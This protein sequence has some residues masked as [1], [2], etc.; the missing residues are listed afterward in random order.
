MQRNAMRDRPLRKAAVPD[1][2][3]RA[4]SGLQTEI[5]SKIKD[6]KMPVYDYACEGCGPFTAMRPMAE[7]DASHPCPECG[8]DA[9]RAW[10]SA[11]RLGVMSPQRRN[12]FATNERSAQAPRSSHGAGCACCTSSNAKFG[13]SGRNAA[14]SFPGKRPWMISH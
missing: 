10:L 8:E 11:P 3:L 13:K 4:P 7:C 12:A 2:A 5:S 6:K 14:K 9:A 1:C